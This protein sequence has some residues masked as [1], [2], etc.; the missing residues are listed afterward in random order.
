MPPGV[1]EGQVI[2]LRGVGDGPGKKGDLYLKVEIRKPILKR[3]REF[4]KV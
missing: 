4:L 2:R 3:V 1:R